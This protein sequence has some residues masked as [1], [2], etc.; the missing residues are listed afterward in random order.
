MG[1]PPRAPAA[2]S[3]IPLHV[4]AASPLTTATLETREQRL[5]QARAQAVAIADAPRPAR[6]FS[7]HPGAQLHGSTRQRRHSRQPAAPQTRVRR[8]P[9]RKV[10]AAAVLIVQVTLLILALTL[11][12]LQVRTISVAGTRVLNKDTVLAA[13]A[14]AHQSIF[15]VDTQSIRGRLLALPWVEDVT[16]SSE[17]PSTV[18][19]TVT[20]RQPLLRVH[21]QG[22]DLYLAGNG[23]SLVST[24]VLAQHLAGTPVLLDERTG[25]AQMIDPALIQ[26][27]SL[28]AQRFPAIFGCSVVAF[29]WGVDN[30]VSIWANTGWRAVLGHLDTADALS[31]LPAQLNALA[32]L[33]GQLDFHSPNFGYVDVENPAAPAV[34]G[35]PGLPA[36]VTLLT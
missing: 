10:I 1:G 25:S 4:H 12:G 20:E 21:R 32:Q 6:R 27:L 36:Q 7:S 11:P 29:D 16:V 14:V 26:M 33:R 24:P 22:R 15:T 17:L 31:N 30:V 8:S 19:I 2:S 13:A 3:L 34:A 9:W 28:T 35:K 18:R 5:A 23:A